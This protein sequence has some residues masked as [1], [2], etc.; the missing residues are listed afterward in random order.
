MSLSYV[1]VNGGGAVARHAREPTGTFF[2]EIT[3][4]QFLPR[5]PTDVM[6]AAVIALNA[7][8]TVRRCQHGFV[9]K[10]YRALQ[11]PAGR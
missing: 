2:C 8:S 7:Y 6:F 11:R 3:T 1:D 9:E 10:L 4:A 5:T